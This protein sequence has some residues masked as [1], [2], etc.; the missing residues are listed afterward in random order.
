MQRLCDAAYDWVSMGGGEC[1]QSGDPLIFILLYVGSV[2]SSVIFMVWPVCCPTKKKRTEKW[3]EGGRLPAVVTCGLAHLV[4]KAEPG[5]TILF[6]FFADVIERWSLSE[7]FIGLGIV[8]AIY[9]ILVLKILPNYMKD[10]QPYSLKSILTK[11]NAFQVLSSVYI[12]YLV[13]SFNSLFKILLP[14]L[15]VIPS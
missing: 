6:F 7:T 11:Y 13:Q 1:F 5:L 10:R 14:K 15:Y 2:S 4:L 8:L 3:E 9:L 12:V